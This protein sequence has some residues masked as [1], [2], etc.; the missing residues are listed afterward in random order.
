[1]VLPWQQFTSGHGLLQP[2]KLF[3]FHFILWF[4]NT[5]LHIYFTLITQVHPII[6][7]RVH[8]SEKKLINMR[9]HV[10]SFSIQKL[11]Y[12]NPSVTENTAP[13]LMLLLLCI[14]N[15]MPHSDTYYKVG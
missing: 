12:W 7:T 14:I 2:C 10:Y 13:V 3:E 4:P 1:M 9:L 11:Y 6:I 8:A 5:Y 15:E